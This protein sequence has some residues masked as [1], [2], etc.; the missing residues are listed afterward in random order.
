M[1]LYPK[2][3]RDYFADKYKNIFFFDIETT[4]LDPWNREMITMSLSVC[5][6]KEQKEIDAIEIKMRPET[7]NWDLGA[8]KVHKIPQH[9]A[10]EFPSRK[11]GRD[12]ILGFM[13][14]YKEDTPQVIC[15]HALD[16]GKGL[17]DWNFLFAEFFKNGNHYELYKYIHN[18][19]STITFAQEIARLGHVKFENNKL[20]TLSA[21]Y[22]IE[23]DHHDAKSDRE[24]CQELYW[25]FMKEGTV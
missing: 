25:R 5:D 8:E 18:V 1:A 12:Q 19:R 21:H 20:N 9:V 24:A 10:R 16:M 17:F 3:D 7:N 15:C 14:F 2:S 22:G 11:E 6:L 13:D 4:G 23:L